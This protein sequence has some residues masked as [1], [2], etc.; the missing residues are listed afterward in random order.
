MEGKGQAS[1]AWFW[2]PYRTLVL[3]GPSVGSVRVHLG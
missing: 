2:K 3:L 1:D